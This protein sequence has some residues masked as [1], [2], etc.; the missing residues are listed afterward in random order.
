MHVYYEPE[1][2][3]WYRDA[4]GRTFQVVA[5]DN[6][7]GTVDLQYFGG[8]LEEMALGAWYGMSFEPIGPPEDW[9]GPFDDLQRDDLGD[10]DQATRPEEWSGPWEEIERES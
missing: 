2:D 7:E 10:T 9:T 5:V 1:I 3:G 8:E 4:S 6:D